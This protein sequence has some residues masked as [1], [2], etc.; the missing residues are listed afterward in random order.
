[1]FMIGLLGSIGL[2]GTSGFVGELL[3]LVASF[4][5]SG[6]M[7][8]M[9]GGGI[10]LSAAYALWLYKRVMLGKIIDKSLEKLSDLILIEKLYL[11]PII[12]SIIFLGIYPKPIFVLSET[13]IE[14]IIAPFY[15]KLKLEGQ[16]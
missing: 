14:K 1:V 5:K 2:P 15:T 4:E 11:F 12:A 3:V 8:F 10:V 6:W 13:A 9:M 16:L 7:A